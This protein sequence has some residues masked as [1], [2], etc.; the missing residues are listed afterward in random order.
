MVT[1]EL[2]L[3]IH[4]FIVSMESEEIN[5]FSLPLASGKTFLE[6]RREKE[7]D[8]VELISVSVE[9]PEGLNFIL[10]QSHFIKTVE[11]LHEAL[12]STSPFIKFGLAFCESSGPCLVRWSGN[13]PELIEL[14]RRNAQRIASGHCFII[15][16]KDAFPINVLNSV[17]MVPEVCRIFCATANPVTVI[18]AE[19]DQ[20]RGILGV[21]DGFKTKGVEGEEEIKERKE[22]L[23]KFGYKL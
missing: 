16:L 22:L 13:D 17:K 5:I 15:F 20:G 7:V 6:N 11:D 23:R 19:N 3:T 9:N 2:I 10:G 21:I 18:L 4:V 14:A 12:I 1:Q 8:I